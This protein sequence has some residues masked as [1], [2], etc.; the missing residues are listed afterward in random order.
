MREEI[1]RHQNDASQLENLYRANRSQFRRAFQELFP[2][3]GNNTLLD[4]WRIRLN[5][6]TSDI[7]KGS[8]SEL[9]FVL[10]AALIAG[11]VARLPMLL[12]IQEEI[13][14]SR[15]LGFIIFPALSAYYA[16]KN[17]LPG[18]KL[19]F[20]VLCTLGAA[21]F[22]NYL[23]KGESDVI[24]LS[25]IH[26]PLFLWSVLAFAFS[27]GKSST[28]S[29]RLGFLKYNG[30]L[31]VISALLIIAGIIL[32]AITLGLFSVI[33]I[34][35]A[36]WYFKNVVVF[37]APAVPIVGTYLIRNNPRLVGRV[38]PV[39]ARI[40]GPLVFVMLLVYLVA[41]VYSGSDPYNDREFLIVFNALLIGVMAIIFFSLAESAGATRSRVE[42]WL[43]LALAIVTVAVN[44]IALSAILFRISEWGFTPNRTAVMGGNILMLI[45]L[46]LV[47]VKFFRNLPQIK[48]EKGFYGNAAV[49]ETMAWYLPVYFVWSI[50]VTFLFP[51]IFG[52][53]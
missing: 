12:P 33:G 47:T 40:F 4:Y 10:V 3:T 29:D 41:M 17:K 1:S 9:L 39:I 50:V 45:H 8:A 19:L 16:W 27:P 52:F 38:S 43:L 34:D 2:Q 7:N 18:S 15:N 42:T 22:I 49:A 32:S 26:L 53:N 51:A 5:Y 36:E 11:C 35:I 13:F 28:V 30:D 21:V 46:L 44:C 48:T 25:C 37:V 24:I 23:P 14:Y 6:D 20:L 31:L